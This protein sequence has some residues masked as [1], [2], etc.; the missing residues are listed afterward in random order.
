[1]RASADSAARTSNDKI[2]RTGADNM[3][4]HMRVGRGLRGI[5]QPSDVRSVCRSGANPG[6]GRGVWALRPVHTVRAGLRR[7]T[8]DDT[9][10][11]TSWRNRAVIALTLQPTL[12]PR[13]GPMPSPC[14]SPSLSLPLSLSLSPSLSYG[15]KSAIR[16]DV[17]PPCKAYTPYAPGGVTPNAA[18]LA[19]TT[20][21]LEVRGMTSNKAPSLDIH[22]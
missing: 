20:I 12:T 17:A 1:M 10:R 16:C 15:A 5:A 8:E 3:S 14:P 2:A 19:S 21:A 22:R 13:P 9:T 11:M 18:T 6:V 7:R 4:R